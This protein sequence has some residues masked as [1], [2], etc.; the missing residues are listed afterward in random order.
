MASIDDTVAK[1]RARRTGSRAGERVLESLKRDAITELVGVLSGFWSSIEEQVRLAALAG[2]DFSAAQ[3]DR[4]AVIAL[5][6]RALELATRY[7]EAIEEA[8]ERW[9]EPREEQDRVQSL[10]LMSEGELE[11]HLAGQQI[12]ELLEHQFLHPLAQLDERLEALAVSLDIEGRP[13]NPLRPEVAVS[14]F[15]DLFQ[16]DDLT[17]SLRT[18]VFHQFDKR[19]PKVLGEVYAKA[20]ATLQTAAFGSGQRS[21]SAR[22]G[23][24]QRPEAPRAPE[25]AGR[26]ADA[27]A[28][29]WVPDGGL[30]EHGGA[31]GGGEVRDQGSMSADFG[32]RRPAQGPAPGGARPG[33]DGQPLRY[34]DIVREQLRAWRAQGGL[35]AVPAEGADSVAAEI[36][37]LADAASE[38]VGQVLGTEDMLNIASLLQGDDPSPYTRALAGEDQRNLAEVIRAEILGGVRQ[39][40]FDPEKTR[41]SADEE[42]AIDLVGILF[43]S[44]FTANDLLQRSRSLYGKL[45]VPYVKVALTDDSLFNRRSHPAR[46][47]LD[48]LTEACDGN[49]GQTAQDQETLDKAEHAVDRV[50]EEYQEDQAVFE[51]AAAELRDQLDQQRKRSDIAEKRAAEAIHGR[52]R[53]QM[54]RR[55]AESLV[56]SRMADR[57]L[58]APVGHFLDQHWRHYL[59]QTWLRD[60]PESERHHAAIGLGDA[61]VQVD[62]D[63][64]QVRGAAVADQLLALQVPLGECYSSCGLDATAARDAMARIISALAMPDTPRAVRTPTGGE[65]DEED[66]DEA[67]LPLR[68]AGGTDEVACDPAIAARMRRLRVGQGLRMIDRG[69]R[70]TAARIAWISPLTSRFLIVNRRGVRKMVVSPEELGLLVASG[71]VMVRSVDAPFDEAMK[72]LW[73]RLNQAPA[74]TQKAA[75]AG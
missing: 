69:G 55:N 58:T 48:A 57:A 18:M 12:T 46:Q 21:A 43:Q 59:T 49:T 68:L 42:D 33:D 44:L 20:N 73:Q 31:G 35:H 17:P 74:P 61:M 56:A 66:G 1:S 38:A 53:L 32:G 52:E 71:R 54:A 29:G 11:I 39:L 63:A 37:A 62:A 72:Q 51:L 10:E 26:A 67:M 8:F 6:H 3:E 5:S 40:G 9:L 19:L 2:H 16:A 28:E 60:G 13:Q 30:V 70:E 34:R 23:G 4:V 45:V 75:N 25:R 24:V 50:V 7:R 64:A 65:I 22:R 27:P 47:L 14:A 41:F 36:G 15:V